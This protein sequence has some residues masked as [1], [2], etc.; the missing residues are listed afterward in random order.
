MQTSRGH[1]LRACVKHYSTLISGKPIF[2]P[3]ETPA[4]SGRTFTYLRSDPRLGCPLTSLRNMS[5]ERKHYAVTCNPPR[6]V[7]HS[8][9]ARSLRGLSRNSCH[10]LRMGRMD[11]RKYCH[12]NG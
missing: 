6:R 11:A 1:D 2:A 7:A 4:Q 10:R 12:E 9:Y 3:T 8:S 5:G